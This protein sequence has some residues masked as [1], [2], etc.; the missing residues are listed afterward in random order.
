MRLFRSLHPDAHMRPLRIV[1]ADYA[2]QNSPAFIAGS[3]SHLVQPF[4]LQYPVG[5]LRDGVLK[6]ISA[7][8]HADAYTMALQLSH[9]GIAAVLAASVGVVDESAC[10]IFIYCRQSHSKG[11]QRV[12]SLQCWTYG[13]ANYL[14]RVCVG[15]QRQVAYALVCLHIRDVGHPYL[16]R[17]HRNDIRDEVRIFP[18]VVV[19]VCRAIV[20]AA[21]QMHHQAVLAQYLDERIPARHAFVLLE[22]LLHYQIQLGAPQTWIVL[23]V[24]LGL[25]Y[26]KRLDCVLGKVIVVPLVVRLPAV[27]K[28]P[29]E[30]AQR[31]LLARLA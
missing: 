26:D 19:G 2:L 23:A 6:R 4:C 3:D 14:V 25:L 16:V 15:N 28:Q 1:E 11:L 30:G 22:Q 24:G 17:T 9:I 31:C 10:R 7:L 8:G 12:D 18:V 27:T 21:A 13:P 5:A 20:P 29:A